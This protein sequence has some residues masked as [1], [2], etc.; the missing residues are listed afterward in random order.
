MN[1]QYRDNGPWLI[2]NPGRRKAFGW[3]SMAGALD[4]WTLA[5]A[6]LRQIDAS[7]YADADDYGQVLANIESDAWELGQE[8][9][10]LV[11]RVLYE[12]RLQQKLEAMRQWAR[13]LPTQEF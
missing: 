5:E 9:I 2:M 11:I 10:E 4:L 7:D 6:L 3:G 8:E 13:G 12:R 1:V